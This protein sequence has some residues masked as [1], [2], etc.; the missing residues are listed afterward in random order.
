MRW[1]DDRPVVVCVL[2]GRRYIARSALAN[3]MYE[4]RNVM[5]AKI[6]RRHGYRYRR[7]VFCRPGARVLLDDASSSAM[8]LIYLL[9]HL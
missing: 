9:L 6:E 4:M 5:K 7:L 8:A 1:A 2:V 3:E